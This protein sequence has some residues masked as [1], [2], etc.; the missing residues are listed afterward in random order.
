M[1]KGHRGLHHPARQ[2]DPQTASVHRGKRGGPSDRVVAQH[3]QPLDAAP[4]PA[5]RLHQQDRGRHHHAVE[6]PE[7]LSRRDG[8]DLRKPLRQHADQP[9]LYLRFAPLRRDPRE[10]ARLGDL[11]PL[12]REQIRDGV[13]ARED[14]SEHGDLRVFRSG[15]RAERDARRGGTLGAARTPE[16][17]RFGVRHLSLRADDG[18]ELRS[19]PDYAYQRDQQEPRPAPVR[20][21]LGVHRELRGRGL[22]TVDQGYRRKDGRRLPRRDAFGSRRAVLRLPLQYVGGDHRRNDPLRNRGR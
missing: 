1:D 21:A 2:R 5:H 16:T 9:A 15:G 18:E 6:D 7:R 8:A 10:R 20:R 13:G 19:S 11:G 4:C 12:L 3:H 14:Q 17:G 22:R